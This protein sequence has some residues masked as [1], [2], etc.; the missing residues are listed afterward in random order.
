MHR[1]TRL[2]HTS[3][4]GR[5]AAGRSRT[6]LGR[7]LCSR[8]CTPQP[9]HQPSAAVVSTACSTSPPYSD[10]AST[11]NP[12][13]PSITA[14]AIPSPCTW[15]LLESMASDTSIVRSQV[16]STAQAA[17]YG[18]AR[19]PRLV[20]KS[21]QSAGVWRG[22]GPGSYRAEPHSVRPARLCRRQARWHGPSARSV[23]GN[24][25]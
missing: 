12:G 19:S 22:G 1:H 14:V 25:A 11:T 17:H 5:P 2:T 24:R 9:A 6:Q 4:T 7:R 13:N 21:H 16:S 15:D 23:A 18:V 20:E 8:A 10:T 3:V